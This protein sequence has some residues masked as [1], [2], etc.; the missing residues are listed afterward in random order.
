MTYSPKV[1][2][3]K[4]WINVWRVA[5]PVLVRE[6]GRLGPVG[7]IARPHFLSPCDDSGF[8]ESCEGV[9]ARGRP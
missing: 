8:A 1:T 7:S 4:M 6:G 5:R 2:L 9:S 3:A